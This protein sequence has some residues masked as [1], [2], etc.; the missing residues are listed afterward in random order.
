M[1]LC[2]NCNAVFA[3]HWSIFAAHYNVLVLNLLLKYPPVQIARIELYKPQF[4]RKSLNAK[5]QYLHCTL[6]T[7]LLTIRVTRM[8]TIDY[9]NVSRVIV[10]VLNN[11]GFATGR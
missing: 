8:F 9:L 4:R 1:K 7:V 11:L 6:S 5:N 10:N 2:G 3:R